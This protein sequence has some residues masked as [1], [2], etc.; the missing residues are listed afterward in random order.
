MLHIKNI[1]YRVAGRT[2]LEE[3]SLHIPVG[4]KIG[5]IGRNGTGKSTLLKLITGEI[6]PEG[7]SIRLQNGAKL[8]VL[9]QEAPSGPESLLETVLDA[10][11]ERK[12]LLNEAETAE[13]PQRIAEI[14]T[15]LADINSHTAES[16]AAKIL[17]GLG[18]DF[19]A[20]QRPCSSYSGGWRTRVALAATLF[21]EPDLLLLDEPSNYLDLEATLWLENFLRNYPRTLVM[22]SHDRNLLNNVIE[23]IV[24]LDQLKLVKYNGNYDFFEKTRAEKLALDAAMAKKQ[25]TQR[26]HLQSFVDRF[27]AKASKARQAQ[28][29]VKMLE[30]MKPIASAMEEYSVNFSFPSPAPLSSPIVTM[31]NCEVGYE[32]TKPIL[33]RLNLR[34]D[35]E[36]RI[37]LL[38][39]NGNGK[40]TF[41]KLLAGKLRAET[42]QFAKSG[43]LKI[44]FFGQHTLDDLHP[45][46][47]AYQHLV[48][49][50]GNGREAVV[51]SKLGQFGFSK[52]KSDV[53]VKKLSGGE[54]ARLIF[55][56]L[57]IDAPHLLILDEP[58]NHLDV[59]AREA[60]IQGLNEFEGAVILISHDPHLVALVADSL[61]LVSG[62]TVTTYDGD[63][64][65]Y[66]KQ[67]IDQARNGGSGNSPSAVSEEKQPNS[68]KAR[69]NS[70]EARKARAEAR[71][72][73]APKKKAVQKL[74]K[75]IQSLQQEIEKLEIKLADPTTY[76]KG[77]DYQASVSTEIGRLKAE[78]EQTE[79]NWLIALEELEELENS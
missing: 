56:L 14:Y 26:K 47:T 24:H 34:L 36:D 1:T 66:K 57:S 41:A 72:L 29:R 70:K 68:G 58:T 45:E 22:V 18:F 27:R 13:D 21:A 54:K 37:A 73:L 79:E 59:D 11:I 4:H 53:A 35:M 6:H 44:G 64:D 28:S 55:C 30:K 71:A 42:G 69:G 49:R 20:Q 31:E 5:L 10:D 43:K 65:D 48:E 52:D 78:Q 3:T 23:T 12:N 2:L 67:V 77:A 8:G 15:R 33:K 9:P 62:G 25:D 75:Q 40:S 17:T 7:G 76:E 19:E 51:R 39:P 60:L 61:W 63:I 50:M 46:D 38:G 32:A 74:E 16:R